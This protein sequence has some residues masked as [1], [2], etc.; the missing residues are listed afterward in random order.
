MAAMTVAPPHAEQV[1]ARLA[2]VR[3]Q[4]LAAG[5][6]PADV[7]IVAVTKG[8]GPDAA[9]AALANGLLDLGESYAQ[10]LVATSGG[11][12]GHAGPAPRWHFIGHLQRRKVRLLAPIVHLWQSVDRH[13]LVHQIAARAPGAGVLVQVALDAEPG[14][15]GCSPHDV[16]ALVDAARAAGL[17]VR[18]LMAVGPAAGGPEAARPGFRRVV[19]LAERLALREVSLGM[20][21]D[22]RIA[23]EEGTTMVR[24]GTT[25]FGPRP[26][27]E[28]VGAWDD[29]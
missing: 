8:H 20:S 1:A 23:L 12:E 11:V 2:A 10:E 26:H 17:D 6:D 13:E 22:L 7:T 28:P 4:I 9:R 25:L 3:A 16:P 24:L 5:R 27:R 29:R 15:S 19:E 18:G 14:R 21:G